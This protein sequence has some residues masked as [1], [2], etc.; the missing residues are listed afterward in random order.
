MGESKIAQAGTIESMDCIVTITKHDGG[1]LIEV[2]GSGAL[3]FAKAIESRVNDVL[4]GLE[5]KPLSVKISVQNNGASD[6]VIGARVEAAY[7]RFI[8]HRAR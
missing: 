2:T 3:R 6:L 8:G 5:K 4:D 7:L 1:R